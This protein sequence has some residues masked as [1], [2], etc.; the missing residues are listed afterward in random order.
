MGDKIHDSCDTASGP[1]QPELPQ[2]AAVNLNKGDTVLSLL[3][4]VSV[5]AGSE[6]CN[7]S[8]SASESNNRF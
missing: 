3:E 7:S 6:L 2:F 4:T 8:E 1:S 5:S